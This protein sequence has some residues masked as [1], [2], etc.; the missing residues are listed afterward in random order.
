MTKIRTL[1]G[2]FPLAAC[3]SGCSALPEAVGL[4]DVSGPSGM[5]RDVHGYAVDV[6]NARGSVTVV[7]DEGLSAPRVVATSSDGMGGTGPATWTAAEVVSADPFPVLR[8]LAEDGGEKGSVTDISIRVPGCVG[9]RIRNSGGPV[10]VRGITGAIDVQ[11]GSDVD[12]GGEVA[13][14]VGSPLDAPF[15]ARAS[16]GSVRVTMPRGSRGLFRATSGAGVVSLTARHEK[17][18]GVT[19]SPLD[20]SCDVNDGEHEARFIAD[21]GAVIIHIP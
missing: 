3:L 21:R 18:S 10:S 5:S 8:V 15:I 9:V 20:W 17:V 13:I 12:E 16:D 6:H 4:V 2:L 19:G 11:N 1:L 14:V 7:V